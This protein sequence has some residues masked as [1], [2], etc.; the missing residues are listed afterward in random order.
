MIHGFIEHDFLIKHN[1]IHTE[2]DLDYEISRKKTV[3]ETI[4]MELLSTEGERCVC[5]NAK[6]SVSN[7]RK[8]KV[9]AWFT[10]LNVRT[11]IIDFSTH[12][13]IMLINTRKVVAETMYPGIIYYYINF[14]SLF[15]SSLKQHFII[16]HLIKALQPR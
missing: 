1:L 8:T 14:L 3:T 15:L 7:S 10:K 4:S 11:F 2:F 6:S 12:F 5:L 9:S 16:K 13:M